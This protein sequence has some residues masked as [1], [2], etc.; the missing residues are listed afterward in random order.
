MQGFEQARLFLGPDQRLHLTA[1]ACKSK[2]TFTM[3]LIFLVDMLY[4]TIPR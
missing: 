3:T 2:Y 4:P 1:M